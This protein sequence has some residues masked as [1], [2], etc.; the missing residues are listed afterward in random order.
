MRDHGGDLDRA[1]AVYGGGDWLDLS[2]GINRVPYPMPNLAPEALT[3]LPLGRDI[4]AVEKAARAA[5]GAPQGCECVALAGASAAIQLLPRLSRRRGTAKV[6]GP[7]YNEHAAALRAAR[8]TVEEVATLDALDDCSVAVVVNPNNPDGQRH[9]PDALLAVSERVGLLVVDES[10][11]DAAPELSI[12]PHWGRLREGALVVV[13]RSFGKFYGLA[14][15]RLGFA[16]SYGPLVDDMRRM[17]GPWAVCGP[18]IAAGQAAYADTD[19]QA[20]T[21]ARLAQDAE[22]MDRLAGQAGWA[23]VGGTTLF[24]TYATPDAATAQDRLAQ[25]RVWTRRFPYSD[26]WLR[27]GLPGTE[28]E[29]RWLAQAMG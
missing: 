12:L 29:W 2:T 20:A 27:L 15:L 24:R 7:T 14:G 13:L 1:R 26:Q 6:L 3:A 25:G 17:A 11:A 19:W 5:F 21:T 4:A 23:L 22:R 18:A 28:A 10:F 16:L 8:W 9:D